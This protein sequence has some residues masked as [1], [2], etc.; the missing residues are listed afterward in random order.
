M[1]LYCPVALGSDEV[2]SGYGMSE[3]SQ[4]IRVDEQ[5]ENM[6]LRLRRDG[7]FGGISTNVGEEALGWGRVGDI[8]GISHRGKARAHDQVWQREGAICICAVGE[9]PGLAKEHS[10]SGQG[11]GARF[12]ESYIAALNRLS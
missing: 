11:Q 1:P 6:G 7:R 10:S 8:Q 2:S 3:V 12:G 9:C 4:D 5:G